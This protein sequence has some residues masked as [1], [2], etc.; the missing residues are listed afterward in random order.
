MTR[1]EFTHVKVA[2]RFMCVDEMRDKDNF[3]R[4]PNIFWKPKATANE[5]GEKPENKNKNKKT[6]F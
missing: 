1:T 3:R 5:P 2:I 4:N 6:Y